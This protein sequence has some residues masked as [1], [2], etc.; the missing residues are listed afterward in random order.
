MPTLRSRCQRLNVP[1]ASLQ[2]KL[3]WLHGQRLQTPELALSLAMGNPQE[4]LRLSTQEPDTLALRQQW[5]NWLCSPEQHGQLPTGLEKAGM[6]VLL[7][8]AMTLLSDMAKLASGLPAQAFPWASEHLAWACA[9]QPQRISR[10]FEVLK[11]E[12]AVA[13]HPLNP[14][15]ALEFTAQNWQTLSQSI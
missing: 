9:L 4:A 15:L 13:T 7:P 6:A 2:E 11:S 8:L 12:Y 5:L 10:V 3:H 1:P 14:R